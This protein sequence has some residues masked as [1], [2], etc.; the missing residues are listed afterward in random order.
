MDGIGRWWDGVELAVTGLSFV[1]Q[2]L[3]VLLVLIPVAALAARVLDLL[4]GA[5]ARLLPDRTAA[6][7]TDPAPPAAQETED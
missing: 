2:V 6:A 4:V 5:A 7:P 3:V 1:P